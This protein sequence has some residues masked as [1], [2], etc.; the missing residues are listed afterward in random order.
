MSVSRKVKRALRGEVNLITAGREAVR[1]TLMMLLAR[2][3]RASLGKETRLALKPPFSSLTPAELLAHF[4]NKEP[5]QFLFC[6]NSSP[7]A[8]SKRDVG[9]WRRDPLSGYLWPLEYHR[10]LKLMRSDGSDVRV[11]WEVNRLGHLL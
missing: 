7:Q 10:D 11:L 8:L 1:R 9:E 4:Q 5:I 2:R 3:E 6:I